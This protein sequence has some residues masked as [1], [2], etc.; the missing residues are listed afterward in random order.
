MR[1]PRG[2]ILAY[3][4]KLGDMVHKGDLVAEVIDPL[5]E[6]QSSART[7]MRAITD[8]IVV[9]RLSKKLVPPG[10][11]ITMVAGKEP[12]PHRKGPLLSD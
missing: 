8:G 3:H 1:A 4:V 9:S 12:L 10:E 6:D 2:G 7:E 11:G 5:A